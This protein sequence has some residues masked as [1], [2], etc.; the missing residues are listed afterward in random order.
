MSKKEQVLPK[1][2]RCKNGSYEARANVKGIQIRLYNTNLKQLQKDFEIAKE[3]AR[4]NVDYKK[5]GITLNEW[6]NEWFDT[7][8]ARK[9]KQTSIYPMKSRFIKTFGFYLGEKPLKDITALDVQTALNAMQDD[10][11]SNGTMRDVLG[12]L[13]ECMEFAVANQYISYNPCSVV[14]VLPWK[15]KI[16][17]EETAL[18]QEEQNQFLTE[19]EKENNWYLEMFYIMF[20]T[21]V[22]VGELGALRWEDIDFKNKCINVRSSLSC[23]YQDG[24]KTEAIVSP[25]T[26]NSYR[27]IPF[28]GEAEEMLLAWKE[29]QDTLR[30]QLG[31]RWRC[32]VEYGNLVFCTGMGSPATRYIVQKEIKKVIKRIREQQAIEAV[33]KGLEPEQ[34]RD[35]HPHT[36]RHTFATRCFE[37]GMEPKVVQKI[38]GH[39]SISIT[40]NIYTHVLEEKQ[41]SE[42]AKFGKAKTDDIPQFD[43][44][45]PQ[46]TAKSHC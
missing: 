4:K 36:I 45:I 10:G 1:G 34:F 25:K 20:L 5:N 46:I 16:T 32:P 3:Q 26:V 7:V 40:L 38:L 43:V 30:K 27:K 22:R 13:R 2:I 39:S 29:K 28:I 44:S 12:R 8:K 19:L 6:F 23:S 41:M 37:A 35:F 15:D 33:E 24:I 21:G 9:I 17:E 14:E 11:K 31:Q 18:T 42:I